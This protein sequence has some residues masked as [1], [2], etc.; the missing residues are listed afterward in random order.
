MRYCGWFITKDGARF[1]QKNMEALQA[2]QDPQNGADLVQ[3][4]AAV[5]WM[6]SAIPNC[7]KRMAPPQTA[8]AKVFEGKSR[9]TKKASA[10]V[11]L[12]HLWGPEEQAAFKDLQ[13]AIMDSMTLAFPD[14]DKRICVLTDAPDRFYAGFVTQIDEEQLDLPMD[15]QDHQLLAFVSGEFKGAQLRWTVP[16]MEGFAIVDTVTKMDC[17]LLSHDEFSILS[18]H[19]NITYIYNPLSADPTLARHVVHNWALKMSMF[20]YRMEHVM[21]ELDY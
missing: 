13:A 8:L 16:E 19:L 4:V 17:L 2:V 3:Y 5:N 1:D 21:G 12:L 10:A 9:R 7:S 14:P 18:D 15:E 6:R 20:S 11:S